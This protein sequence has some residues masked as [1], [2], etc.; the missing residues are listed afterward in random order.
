[1]S[2]QLKESQ[3][4]F[5]QAFM[6]RGILD[7]RHVKL[8]YQNVCTRFEEEPDMSRLGNFVIT[9]NSSLKPFG[10]E[11]KKGTSEQTGGQFYALVNLHE[12]NITRMCPTYT[13]NDLELF[14]KIIE[15]IVQTDEG[16]TT[17][18][19]VLNIGA[20]MEKKVSKTHA[21][22][23]LHDLE[24]NKWITITDGEISLDTRSLLEL[25][26]YMKTQFEDHVV[27]CTMCKRICLQGQACAQCDVKLHIHCAATYFARNANANA[28]CPEKRCK[29]PWIH[30]IPQPRKRGPDDSPMKA[31]QSTESQDSQQRSRTTRKRRA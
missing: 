27:I 20:E 25:D 4:L 15:A 3:Q 26:Q 8:L 7:C 21:E 9:I 17:T 24:K 5:L 6:S 28:C 11:I 30:E 2:R 10:M 31:S 19:N 14:K 16:C 22:E 23:F 18:V 29:A 1:M 13:P 12:T